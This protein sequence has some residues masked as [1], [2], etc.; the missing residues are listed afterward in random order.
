MSDF[1]PEDIQVQW[2]SV[3]R[4]LQHV[5]NTENHNNY[6]IITINILVDPKGKPRLWSAPSCRVVEPKRTAGNILKFLTGDMFDESDG[7]E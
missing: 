6:A 3:I 2:L 5:A 1:L 4:R 7:T